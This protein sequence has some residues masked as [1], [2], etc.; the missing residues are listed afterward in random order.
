MSLTMLLIIYITN[1][2]KRYFLII[3]IDLSSRVKTSVV[4]SLLLYTSF[5]VYTR[6]GI[7]SQ[8]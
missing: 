6:F 4:V 5:V 2:N 8:Y 7:E 3:I 1:G